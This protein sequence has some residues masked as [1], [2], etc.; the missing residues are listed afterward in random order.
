M[1]IPWEKLVLCLDYRFFWV[2][3]ECVCLCICVCVCVC[4]S[5]CVCLC[6]SMYLSLCVCVGI[7]LVNKALMATYG[8]GFGMATSWPFPFPLLSF[9][10]WF[11]WFKKMSCFFLCVVW[12]NYQSFAFL[13]GVI[14]VHM[15]L[16]LWRTKLFL[17]Q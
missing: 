4:V 11:L 7:I 14:H 8:F 15:C 10:L 16:C 1:E 12:I 9:H 3:T 2:C 5:L 6:M 13:F 17:V